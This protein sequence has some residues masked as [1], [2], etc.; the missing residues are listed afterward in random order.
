MDKM[1]M[2]SWMGDY[3][4]RGLCLSFEK[5]FNQLE[6]A[7]EEVQNKAYELEDTITSLL[8]FEMTGRER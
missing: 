2:S 6:E 1:P 5:L 7:I 3:K 8:P 4:S